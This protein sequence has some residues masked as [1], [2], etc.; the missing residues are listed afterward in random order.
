MSPARRKRRITLLTT[1][2]SDYS[3]IEPLCGQL[4]ELG[5]VEVSLAVVGA[6]TSASIVGGRAKAAVD[7][8]R[9]EWGP[10]FSTEESVEITDQWLASLTLW[11]GSLLD[12]DPPEI[13][14]LVGDRHE[15]IVPA[16]AALIRE[17]P[18]AHVS[19]GD[20]TLGSTDNHVRYALTMLA[21]IHMVANGEHRQRLLAMGEASD[22]VRVT[23]D[24]ALSAM[25]ERSSV[26]RESFMKS[27][28]LPQESKFALVTYH[29]PARHSGSWETEVD[30]IVVGLA[31]F[32]GGVLVTGTNGDLRAGEVTAALKSAVA[33][34]TR[35]AFVDSLGPRRFYDAMHHAALMVGNSSSGIWESPTIGIPVVNIGNRQLGRLKAGNVIDAVGDVG[36]VRAAIQLA[37][38]RE[39]VPSVNPYGSRDSARNA[40][41]FLASVPLDSGLLSK[42]FQAKA[43]SMVPQA[44]VCSE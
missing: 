18:I 30:S 22:L 11:T 12:R 29:P 21:S 7:E 16:T 31:D 4:A 34:R 28:G 24:P 43:Q 8:V 10:T 19:G 2:R 39:H 36:S 6:H 33:S 27:V 41:E 13:L 37:L 1:G 26:T 20:I 14:V 5:T 32:D 42:A 25:P 35:W 9:V 40:A 23:G 15:L 44:E 3:S 17:I 38:T